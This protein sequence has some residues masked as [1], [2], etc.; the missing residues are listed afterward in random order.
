VDSNS[1]ES[2]SQLKE[3]IRNLSKRKL[4]KLAF[5]LMEE[6]EI[7][8]SEN[9]MLKNTC[10]GLEK[11]AKR[12]ERKKQELGHMNEVLTCEKLKIDK[13][14]LV[15]CNEL[16]TLKDLMNKREEVFNTNLSRP[17]SES[18]NLKL[19]LESQMSEN[20]QLLEK[21]EKAKT[22]LTENKHW[23]SSSEALV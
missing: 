15:L 18:L 11:D 19:N 5:T 3:E 9:C 21:M 17:E 16:D 23:K 22:D 1:I 8:N 4:E 13:K 10:S 20:K 14:V 6:C 7:V 12:L 2:L